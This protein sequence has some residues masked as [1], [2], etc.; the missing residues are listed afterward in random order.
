MDIEVPKLENTILTSSE[1]TITRDQVRYKNN[2]FVDVTDGTSFVVFDDERTKLNENFRFRDLLH[3][4]SS[5]LEKLKSKALTD[6]KV[7]ERQE[8]DVE[9]SNRGTKI[10]NQAVKFGAQS[11]MK[12]GFDNFNNALKK[13]ETHLKTVYNFDAMLIGEGKI[14]PPIISLSN[15]LLSVDSEN[16]ELSFIHTRYVISQQAKFISNPISFYTYINLPFQ[17][18]DEPS[19]YSI[20]LNEIELTYWMNGFYEGWVRGQNMAQQLVDQKIF[21]LNRDYIG[22]KRYHALRK[23]NLISSPIVDRFEND[24]YS[25]SGVMD[26][27]QI[28]LKLTKLPNFQIDTSRWKAIPMLDK[29]ETKIILEHDKNRN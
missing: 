28:K 22:M 1:S 21:E 20:P 5:S 26:V 8:K 3:F 24:V 12:S 19:I 10:Y 15:N 17:D 16:S 18:V 13:M 2:N 11:G 23:Q 7:L 27:G 9:N 25:E 4:N 6:E 14:L 29:L